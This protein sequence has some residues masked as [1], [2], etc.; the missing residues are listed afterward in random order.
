MPT[1]DGVCIAGIDPNY[2]SI[3]PVLPPPGVLREHLYIKGKLVIRPSAKVIF[4]F[5]QVSIKPPHIENLGFDP[6]SIEYLGLCD[7][8]EWGKVLGASSF[9]TVEDIYDGLLKEHR[10]V[11]PDANVRS[12]GTVSEVQI[13]DIEIEPLKIPGHYKPRLAFRDSTG[14]IFRL[15]VSDLSFR[16]FADYEISRIGTIL[17]A[18]SQI[19]K[20][21][22]SANRLYLRIGLPGPWRNPSTGKVASWMQVTGIYTFPDYLGG[23]SFADF[24]AT[25]R[26]SEAKA[27]DVKEIREKYS[28]AYTKWTEDEDNSLR[29]EYLRG[30]TVEGLARDFQRKPG[31]IRSRLLRLGLLN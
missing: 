30:K 7:K 29:N 23:K 25:M 18:S 10:W 24:E 9:S 28:K 13:E 6:D 15:P 26:S 21:L 19:L 3:R 4:D 16:A 31:A 20:T 17:A 12:L 11:E 1:A 27:Y 2:Q 22:Q 5:H 14:W 8:S